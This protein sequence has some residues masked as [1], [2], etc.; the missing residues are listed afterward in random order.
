MC[1]GAATTVNRAAIVSPQ[2]T[3]VLFPAVAADRSRAVWRD[4]DT[5]PVQT[6][7]SDCRQ[8]PRHCAPLQ[9]AAEFSATSFP[10]RLRVSRVIFRNDGCGHPQR[11]I[12]L[13]NHQ[14]NADK[15]NQ[16]CTAEIRRAQGFAR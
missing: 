3:P 13:R 1:R 14:A 9:D 11:R 5:S 4:V 16:W 10:T 7:Q 15:E 8:M 12:W 2:K 6:L